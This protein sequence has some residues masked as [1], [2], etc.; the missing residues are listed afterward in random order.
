MPYPLMGL[1]WKHFQAPLKYSTIS[2]ASY[3]ELMGNQADLEICYTNAD[4]IMDDLRFDY[5]S[6]TS[7]NRQFAENGKHR[8]PEYSAIYE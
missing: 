4:S 6:Y 8:P 3:T 5:W 7:G 1:K 2:R